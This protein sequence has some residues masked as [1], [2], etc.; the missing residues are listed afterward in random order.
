[1]GVGK[2]LTGPSYNIFT[3]VLE[4]ARVFTIVSHSYNSLIF[5]RKGVL[6]DLPLEWSPIRGTTVVS[7]SLAQ[8]Y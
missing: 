8:K 1:M 2:N 5:E 4:E 3:A 6:L 7:S